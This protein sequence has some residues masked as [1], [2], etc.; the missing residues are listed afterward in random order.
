LETVP[1][2]TPDSAVPCH[3]NM[4]AQAFIARLAVVCLAATLL[5]P[6][7]RLA[8]A[9]VHED[10]RVVEVDAGELKA[11]IARS[12]ARVVIVNVWATWCKPCRE[13]FPELLRLYRRWHGRGVGLVLVSA[14][15][16]DRLPAVRSFLRDHGVDFETY[17][18]TGPDEAFI[19]DLDR[20]W[21]G[22]LPATFVIDAAGRVRDFWE[23]EA[24][25]ARFE[26][27]IRAVLDGEAAGRRGGAP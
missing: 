5:A 18:K 13:E 6:A 23:G 1:H 14:D 2:A 11:I 17:I 19:D 10:A 9:P 16:H 8:A 24:D 21:S 3:L 4:T 25:Y 20:R 7:A 26:G 27:A 15:F 22:A 12:H